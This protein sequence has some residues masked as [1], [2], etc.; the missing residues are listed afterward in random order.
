MGGVHVVAATGLVPLM[1]G[2]LIRGC[3]QDGSIVQR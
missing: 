1:C 3:V 2:A